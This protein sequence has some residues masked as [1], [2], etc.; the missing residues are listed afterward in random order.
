MMFPEGFWLDATFFV[1]YLTLG[2]AAVLAVMSGG[3]LVFQKPEMRQKLG[4][5]LRRRKG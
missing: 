1:A 5:L 3:Y 4:D 2:G